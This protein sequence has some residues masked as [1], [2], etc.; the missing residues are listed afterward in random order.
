M[1][2]GGGGGIYEITAAP[3]APQTTG[4]ER[5][6]YH[7]DDNDI[8]NHTSRVVT[9][10]KYLPRTA[11]VHHAP[12]NSRKKENRKEYNIHIQYTCKKNYEMMRSFVFF[13]LSI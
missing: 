3:R 12:P 10:Q 13:F 2:M 5:V 7:H 6:I 9:Q 11:C 8:G 1:G 4:T